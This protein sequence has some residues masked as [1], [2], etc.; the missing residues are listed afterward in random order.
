V[1]NYKALFVKIT[2]NVETD[3]SLHQRK[4]HPTA[5]QTTEQVGSLTI[6]G[7]KWC[8]VSVS[9]YVLSC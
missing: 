6:G 2:E 5:S 8:M 4:G 3:C 9:C 7:M 1:R